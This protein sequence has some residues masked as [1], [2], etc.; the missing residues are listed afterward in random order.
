MDGLH[1]IVYA[2]S[3]LPELGTELRNARDQLGMSLQVVAETAKISAA[4]L[5]KLERGQVDT[6]SPHVLRRLGSSL[7]LPYMR[8]MGLAGYLDE[9]EVAE[10]GS[11][12]PSPSPHPLAGRK[13][14][15]EEW[16]AVGAFI[17]VL[18]SQ[19]RGDRAQP[20]GPWPGP[21]EPDAAQSDADVPC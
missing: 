14:T 21:T 18:V 4:Y 10:A 7:G 19:R 8:L 13:L 6:P 15:Q 16:R 9:A 2:E 20:P 11:R 12:E 1:T 17:K 5:Q 3:M